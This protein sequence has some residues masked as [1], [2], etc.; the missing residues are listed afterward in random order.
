MKKIWIA[1]LLFSTVQIVQAQ[2]VSD[3]NPERMLGVKEEVS[4]ESL[5]RK[6]SNTVRFEENKGQWD[7]EILYRVKGGQSALQFGKNKVSV[8]VLE[9]GENK[10]SKH[11]H[12]P[13]KLARMSQ[14]EKHEY[15][16][17]LR[18]KRRSEESREGYVWNL[19]F[20]GAN[21]NPTLTPK[22]KQNSTTNYIQSEKTIGQVKKYE[23][24]WY[25]NLYQ[26]IDMRFYSLGKNLDLEYDFIV[27]PNADPSQVAFSLEGVENI[28]VTPEGDLAFAT[29]FGELKKGA[30]Y[31]YQKIEG[32]IVKVS[33]HYEIGQDGVIRFALPE[34]YRRDLP[35]IIDPL[36]L[37]YSTYVGTI[38]NE[39]DMVGIEIDVDGNIV[40]TAEADWDTQFP[41]TP[42]AYHVKGGGGVLVGKI[43]ADL[44][45]I[46]WA[47]YIGDTE[48]G[49]YPIAIDL[50]ANDNVYVVGNVGN[51]IAAAGG[52]PTTSGAFMET[53]INPTVN[54]HIG[55][56]SKLSSDGSTLVYS[57][58]LRGTGTWLQYRDVSA[59]DVKVDGAGNAVVVGTTRADSYPTTAGV[60]DPIMDSYQ[61]E[62]MFITKLNATGSGLVFSTFLGNYVWNET[63]EVDLDAAGNIYVGGTC[64]DY[65]D[66]YPTTPGVY[67]QGPWVGYDGF[68]TKLNPTGTTLIY[69]TLLPPLIGV[70]GSEYVEGL[71]FEID[72]DGNAYL[73]GLAGDIYTTPGAYL[74]NDPIHR[75]GN[76]SGYVAKFDNTGNLV[77]STY[78][79]PND[80]SYLISMAIQ[81]GK[82][83][84]YLRGNS[85][86]ID[87]TP[88]AIIEDPEGG[89]TNLLIGLN[90][91]GTGITYASYMNHGDDIFYYWNE[92]LVQIKDC[93]LYL[94]VDTN[95]PEHPTT[96]GTYSETRV[97]GTDFGFSVFDLTENT[98]E[99]NTISPTSQVVCMNGRTSVITGSDMAANMGTYFIDGVPYVQTIVPSY[100]WQ[101]STDNI[102]W[103]NIPGALQRNF[104]P[105]PSAVDAYYRRIAGALGCA[106]DTSN[107][108][109]LDV[110]TLQA[111]SVPA[112]HVTTCP[113]FGIQIGGLAS[114]GSGGPYT[115]SWT[116]TTGLDNPSL[117]QPTSTVPSGAIYNVIVTDTGNGCQREEQW[118]VNV[119][120]AD[121]GPDVSNCNG[122][123]AQIGTFGG[124]PY[125]F[126]WSVVSGDPITT[127]NNPNIPQP[128][129]DPTVATDYQLQLTVPG[130]GC[131]TTDTVTVTPFSVT[132]D[133]GIDHTLCQGETA[134]LGEP[135]EAG[136]TYGWAP[137]V[138]INSQVVAQPTL[139]TSLCPENDIYPETSNPFQYVVTKIHTATGCKD[140]DTSS[141]YVINNNPLTE[142]CTPPETI[143]LMK[144]DS[145]GLNLPTMSFTWSVISGDASSIVGQE[146]VRY[147]TVNPSINTT[148]NLDATVNGKTCSGEVEVILNCGCNITANAT[149]DI[150]CPVGGLY[151]TRLQGSYSMNGNNILS[152]GF[153]F[154]WSPA[155]YLSDPFTL[156]PTVSAVPADITYTLSIIDESTGLSICDDDVVVFA[157]VTPSP[158]VNPGTF[159]T[160]EPGI[161]VQIGE[162]SVVGWNYS[163]NPIVGLSDPNISD[164]TSTVLQNTTY[165]LTA[166][167][168]VTG[169]KYSDEN[170][171][172][173]QPAIIDA[174]A[175]GAFC[176]NAIVSLG[177]PPVANQTYHWEP[178][179]GL[180]QPDVAQ[181]LDTIFISTTYILS[182]LDTVTGCPA[183]DSVTY[184]LASPPV[185]NVPDV[186]VCQ[187]SSIQIGPTPMP[188][189]TYQWQP[190]AGLSNP[191][192]AQPVATVSSTT[193][194][195]LYVSDGNPGCYG[196]DQVTITA[197]PSA[198]TLDAPDAS[199]C[200][201]AT[202]TIGPASA[203]GT[204][205]W[206]PTTG[207]SDPNIAQPTVTVADS[208]NIYVLTWLTPDGCSLSDS[209]SVAPNPVATLNA[210]NQSICSGQSVEIGSDSEAGVTYSWASISGDPV[211]TLS[212]PNIAKPIATPTQTT[213]YRL[214]ATAAS[215][216]QS[217]IDDTVTVRPSPVVDL[218]SDLTN[219]CANTVL[220]AN[221]TS[222]G[223]ASMAY[224][225]DTGATTSTITVNPS[226]TTIYSVTVTNDSLCT[227]LDTIQVSPTFTADAGI[228]REICPGAPIT[229][230]T[231]S[232]GG[233][234]TYS[235]TPT[236]GLS[237]SAI[238]QPI[239]SPDSTTTYTV[240]IDNG[241]GCT[242]TDSMTV[243]VRDAPSSADL[244]TTICAG[245]CVAIGSPAVSNYTYIWSPTTGLPDSTTT[246]LTVCPAASI[247]YTLTAIN[248]NTG[249]STESTIVIN[250]DA[251]PAPVP[252]AGPDVTVCP[253]E[254]FQLGGPAVAGYTYSWSSPDADGV[255][256]LDDP[257]I[258]DPTG[259]VAFNLHYGTLERTFIVEMLNTT[260]LC[261]AT[262][263][264]VVTVGS[265]PQFS[266]IPATEMLCQGASFQPNVSVSASLPTYSWVPTIGLSNPTIKNPVMTPTETT[267]YTLNVTSRY[268]CS[269]SMSFLVEVVP[270]TFTIDVGPDTT[271]CTGDATQ[272]GMPSVAGATYAWTPTWS[273]YYGG[274]TNSTSAQPTTDAPTYQTSRTY[275]LTATAPGG[276]CKAYDDIRI[277]WRYSVDTVDAGPDQTVCG[278]ST[279]LAAVAPSRGTRTWSQVSGPN[280]AT[281]SST[282]YI[283]DP[284]VSNLIPGVYVFEWTITNVCNPGFDRVVVEVA[285]P[286]QL[287]TNDQYACTVVNLT[288]PAVTT[289]SSNLGT[290]T[291]WQDSTALIALNRP[292]SVVFSGTY[293]IK[294][295]NVQGCSFLEPVNVSITPPPAASIS[296]D[297][298]LAC[299]KTNVTL[300]ALPASGVSYAWSGGGT[301]QTNVVSAVG[302]YT[303]T[304]TDNANGCVSVASTTVTEIPDPIVIASHNG[305]ICEG[306]TIDLNATP[307]GGA[308]PYSF[309]WSGPNSFTSADQNPDLLSTSVAMSGVYTVTVTDSN[310]CTDEASTTVNIQAEPAQLEICTGQ[311]YTLTAPAGFTNMEWF[312]DGSSVGTGVSYVVSLAGV[313]TFTADDSDGCST[314]SCCPITFT[315]G[316]CC[317]DIT[318][319][320]GPHTTCSGVPVANLS[321]DTEVTGVDSIRFV[322][323]TSDQMAGANPTAAESATIYDY[324]SNGG[325]NINATT[326]SGGTAT[327][328]NVAFPA[329]GGASPVTYYVYAIINPDIGVTCRPAQEIVV[330]V[331]PAV[332]ANAG[333]GATICEGEST[334]LSAS[335]GTSYVWDNGLGAGA[336]HAVSPAST[337]TYTV[338]AT[339]A[340]G[341][342]DTDQ[343]TITVNAAPAVDAGTDVGIC[344]GTST[345][346][347]ASGGVNYA[348][349]NGLG[350]G[351][352]HSVSPISTTTY[353]VTVTAANGC[354]ATDQI[355]V[356][357]SVCPEICNN[358][359][360]DNGDGLIDC[361]DAFCTV[362]AIVGEDQTICAGTSTT[363]TVT[364][365]GG[366]GPHTFTWDNGL[367]TGSFETV[368]PPA[369]TTY[370]V[371]VTSADGCTA[372]DNQTVT[373]LTSP[374]DPSIA[375]PVTNTCPSSTVNLAA[376]SAALSPSI[377]GGTFEWHTGA[378]PDSPPVP[379]PAAVSAGTYFLFEKNTDG[380]YSNPFQVLV[381]ISACCPSGDC[382]D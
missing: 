338:T 93:K 116:P 320:N 139:L 301:G 341:C 259:S 369:T 265:K 125:T 148:Y 156:N 92:G 103:E 194:Y 183:V 167:D 10:Q 101:V 286:S 78:V 166:E 302:T 44:S 356:T 243:I 178:A 349:D 150:G 303:V 45:Q 67:S 315:V 360:D 263:T 9:P 69:S 21:P 32:E 40:F 272:F 56:V 65:D 98:G 270:T 127:L 365:S 204:Y 268:G 192:I 177:T 238:A 200:P 138:N 6:E 80:W 319:P 285:N 26:G 218:G 380:C 344:V 28:H 252:D 340:N 22:G 151:N 115:Y 111:P 19:N 41:T 165:V 5:L 260:S 61:D 335:G 119:V 129:A 71:A 283:I 352:S 136:Y 30:P 113:D 284:T 37:L 46:I 308:S 163:W 57:T 89:W 53:T 91:S 203:G 370:S 96:S 347:T 172:L 221:V 198:Y 241:S 199:G 307:I 363:V 255:L 185:V 100:Q 358:G 225:W 182:V 364:G 264:V 1:V 35:L 334:N 159:Y 195:E 170:R 2:R 143:G 52:F 213:I 239:A 186:T 279:T 43:S 288:N 87:P 39:E 304:V 64:F 214:T 205:S 322:Y 128:I 330:T 298:P 55:F 291:Y 16:R 217:Q 368:T 202:V 253:D 292:D 130:T 246:P 373:V 117:A 107:V 324:A 261:S 8:G 382:G 102:N 346:L 120:S 281:F 251:N 296:D 160:C 290:L 305:S 88:G 224:L 157:A 48:P 348:W 374:S 331:N 74:Q 190:A 18:E 247:T 294:T 145:C 254:S 306:N 278:G 258:S 86:N 328:S 179:I 327:L 62:P 197:V 300:T 323:F 169:C 314:V 124:P 133:A 240:A 372:T 276:I 187:G 34:G 49:V 31:A 72:E 75:S 343:V 99:A 245:S 174:G 362:V 110:N 310:G 95:S 316:D 219:I 273:S 60:F 312:R 342:T 329:N 12:D 112:G 257:Y 227:G 209:V 29:P 25:E 269:N 17:A 357:V 191:N 237:N 147:P 226:E 11:R 317:P 353:T 42:G 271:I 366:N 208:T 345:T 63:L 339:D 14:E 311:T 66:P 196:S 106:P 153:H 149:S 4:I 222:G 215:G 242:L 15:L 175:D 207:L 282:N 354:T 361:F 371:T 280:T 309:S 206:T 68:V 297:G 248:N 134:T 36:I 337:T 184:T 105:I 333:T 146:N 249:C 234:Y 325:V 168:A 94:G 351:A 193:T 220:T 181:P 210:S 277:S 262:D 289:G 244:N 155:T 108:H 76:N 378:D 164:P 122:Q 58:F 161:P 336:T 267:L 85:G 293:F 84:A 355:T 38:F 180:S 121:A 83:Y 235:W 126:T 144:D 82:V 54:S 350:A 114:G 162:P 189:F 236:S 287:V 90:E 250:V 118:D 70:N 20:V 135:A 379:N 13:Q 141:V 295:T 137:G 201:G 154:E 299:N 140:V 377:P 233:G 50:D 229:I 359:I 216:C 158:F 375:T 77:Y 23:E 123:P 142:Y 326:P 104:L 231:P 332:T 171:V 131:S 51:G 47:T 33:C 223:T 367:G 97:S 3:V 274:G 212:D 275:A 7:G 79:T 27:H 73:G 59:V 188:G 152:P 109:L 211:S 230:G 24:L 266:S 321:V 81:D 313:Y 381:G 232:L 176:E 256:A 318:M 132:A 228:D 376:I 173:I